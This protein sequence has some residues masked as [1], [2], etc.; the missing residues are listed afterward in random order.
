MPLPRS[1]ERRPVAP[2]A[3]ADRAA[4]ELALCAILQTLQVNGSAVATANPEMIDAVLV[5][6]GGRSDRRTT[7]GLPA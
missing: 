3:A 5:R 6:L 1:V 2:A 4:T 7:G